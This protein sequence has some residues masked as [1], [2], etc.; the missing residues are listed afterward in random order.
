MQQEDEILFQLSF[1]GRFFDFLPLFLLLAVSTFNCVFVQMMS[2]MANNFKCGN[3]V[4]KENKRLRDQISRST[5]DK[6]S[7]EESHAQQ[8]SQLKE[9]ADGFLA[10]QLT[11]EEKLLAAEEEIKLL[12]EQLSRS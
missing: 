1:F 9:S 2:E 5:T 7:V 10:T 8:L 4:S 6:L 12:K 11:A 3:A